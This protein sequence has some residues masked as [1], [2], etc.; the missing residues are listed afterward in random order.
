MKIISAVKLL[1]KD[2]DLFMERLMSYIGTDRQ[3]IKYWF[4]NKMG[5]YPDLDNPKTFNEKLQWLK[6]NYRKPILTTLVDKYAVKK[7]V[8][9]KIGAEYIIPTL[10]VWDSFDEIDFDKLPNQF[11]LKCT[12]DSGGLV[13]CKDKSKL[14]I[15]AA[16]DKIEKSLATDFYKLGREWPYKNVPRRIIA[17]QYMEEVSKPDT[18][19][20]VDYK[21]FC[22]KGVPTYCQVIRDRSSRETIDFYDMEWNHMPFVGLNPVISNGI[23]PVVCPSNFND[24]K[25]VCKELSKDIPFCRV[26]LY[27]VNQKEYFGEITLFPGCG[28]GTFTP[29]YWNKK[30]GDLVDLQGVNGGGTDVS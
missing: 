3:Y 4:K 24:M 19:D 8:A 9:D 22:F 17:E 13:I 25:R 1:L 28:I 6:L 20:L 18:K 2:K 27:E 11:V 16:K 26:D 15:Q 5:Y 7:Y 23:T 14:D 21:F 29:E 12:H 10:G 30:L